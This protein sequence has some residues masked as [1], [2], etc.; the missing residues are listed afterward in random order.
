M[1]GKFKGFKY[2]DGS[3]QELVAFNQQYKITGRAD[4]LEEVLESIRFSEN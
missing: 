4:T 1:N 3:S 2:P